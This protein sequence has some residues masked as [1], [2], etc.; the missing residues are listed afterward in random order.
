MGL[1]CFQCVP[2]AEFIFKIYVLFY[3]FYL[4]ALLRNLNETS[5]DTAPAALLTGSIL[6]CATLAENLNMHGDEIV[7]KRGDVK[8]E[9]PFEQLATACTH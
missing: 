4:L 7:K 8:A 3:L 2:N 5:R 1:F 9:L 6:H